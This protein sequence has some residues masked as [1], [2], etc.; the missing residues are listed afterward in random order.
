[1]VSGIAFNMDFYILQTYVLCTA[2]VQLRPGI[3]GHPDTH[4]TP[5][6]SLTTFSGT[7]NLLGNFPFMLRIHS[8]NECDVVDTRMGW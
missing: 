5:A 8:L 6:R 4:I 7:K 3:R 1:M 2:Y